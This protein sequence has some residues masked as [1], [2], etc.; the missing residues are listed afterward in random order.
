MRKF[1]A[2]FICRAIPSRKKCWILCEEVLD[3]RAP[4]G[5]APRPMVG[6]RSLQVVDA[7]NPVALPPT[8]QSFSEAPLPP[9][10]LDERGRKYRYLR[11]SIIDRCDFACVY[12]MPHGGEEDHALR[13]EML[14]F[15][16][17]ARIVKVFSAMGIERVRLTGGEPLVR[18]NVVDLV[19]QIRAT[20]PTVEIAMTSN[21]SRLAELAAPLKKAGL[22]SINIS[23]DSLEPE[24]FRRLTRGGDL[25]RVLRG[26]HAALDAGL[27]LKFNT[28]AIRGEN[29]HEFASIVDFAWE[30][31]ITPRFIELMPIG[32]GARLPFGAFIPASEIAAKLGPR[33]RFE[34]ESSTG[35]TGPARYACA[36][37]GNLQRKVGFITAISESFCADCNRVRITSSGDI[38]ACIASR[39]AVSLRDVL[40]DDR[41]TSSQTRHQQDSALAW[42]VHWALRSKEAGHFFL[43][44]ERGDHHQ[45]AMSAIGG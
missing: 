45:V 3:A 31:G 19:R 8:P 43:E 29:D 28:V 39:Q 14:S 1:V 20:S 23:V 22:G 33:V 18:K 17:T 11:M 26:I 32:E 36:Q 7:R 44:T 24:R 9:Q 42:A 21:A 5:H 12:C 4:S 2:R 10:L 16:E 41:F 13:R 37:S 6:R 15:E 38:R 27:E 34:L 40:R 35:P 30:R 25:D